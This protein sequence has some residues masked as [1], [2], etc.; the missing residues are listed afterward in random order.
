[1]V[2]QSGCRGWEEAVWGI[3]TMQDGI[4]APLIKMQNILQAQSTSVGE[5]IRLLDALTMYKRSH[6]P[7]CRLWLY[8]SRVDDR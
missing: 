8:Q 4:A 6:Y 3:G 5:R 2:S 1:M 7:D